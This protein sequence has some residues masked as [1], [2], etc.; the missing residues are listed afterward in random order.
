MPIRTLLTGLILTAFLCTGIAF[1][2]PNVI[3]GKWEFK[4][5]TQMEGMAAMNVPAETH[6]QCVT[7]QDLVPLSKNASKE[8][9]ISN[10]RTKGNTVTYDIVCS[11]QGGQM[12]GNGEI[13]Y[14]GDRM[15]GT[16]HITVTGST[17][18]M[19]NTITGRRIG[20]CDGQTGSASPGASSQ[21]SQA[22]SSDQGSGSVGSAVAGDAKDVG[23]AGRQQAKESGIDEVKKG[24]KGMFKKLFD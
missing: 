3:P 18:K 23:Q 15:N 20:P 22:S 11:G 8:C 12:Q 14:N 7:E 10:V 6:I 21:Q 5:E 13:T 19:T 1:A 4:T 17:M 9:R 2:K 16:M 24:V